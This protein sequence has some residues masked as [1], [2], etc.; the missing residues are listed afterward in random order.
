M[1]PLP[2]KKRTQNAVQGTPV[3]SVLSRLAAA[4]LEVHALEEELAAGVAAEAA[5]RKRRRADAKVGP[6]D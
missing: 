3:L 2:P 6:T 1:M 5:S 4:P